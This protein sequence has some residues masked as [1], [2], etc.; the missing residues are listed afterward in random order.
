VRHALA[1][2]TERGVAAAGAV[3]GHGASPNELLICAKLGVEL[4]RIP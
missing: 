4:S 3:L 2:N 1:A